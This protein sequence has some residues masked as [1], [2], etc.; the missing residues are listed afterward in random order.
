MWIDS[1]GTTVL[2]AA[3]CRRLL[4]LAAKE[5]GIGRLGIS[6]DQAP[7]IIPVNFTLVDGRIMVRTGPGFSSGA[8]D[9]HLV[10]FEVDHIDPVTGTAW[11]VLVRG[12]ASLIRV[13]GGATLAAAAH[14]MVPEPGDM[15]LE[16]RP[17]LLTGRQFTLSSG[18]PSPV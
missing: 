18:R 5:H 7:V 15:V 11:S 14:P 1:Q 8:S 13:P 17:D 10:A 16:V 12:L 4:A 3:E 2:P 9:G 6:T